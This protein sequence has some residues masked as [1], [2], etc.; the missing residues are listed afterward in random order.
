MDVRARPSLYG[1]FALVL[2]A[3][4][5]LLAVISPSDPDTF[6]HLKNGEHVLAVGLGSADVFSYTARGRPWVAHEWLFDVAAFALA[7]ALGY[8]ALVAAAAVLQGLTAWL[9]VRLARA[10]GAG[11]GLT[12]A[13]TGA[14]VVFI[15]PT[16]GVRP[17]IVTTLLAGAFSLVLLRY[18]RDPAHPRMLLALPPLMLAWVNLHASFPL[19]IALVAIFLAGGAAQRALYRAPTSTL[20][21]A[22]LATALVACAVATLINPAGV[23]LWTYPLPYLFSGTADI[24]II[25]EWRS[26]DFHDPVNL[27]FA[28]S[29][30]VLGVVGLGRPAIPSARRRFRARVRGRFDPT[31]VAVVAL[32]ATLALR[33]GRLVPVYGMLVLPVLGEAVARAWPAVSRK[34]EVCRRGRPGATAFDHALALVVTAGFAL[35]V[36]SSPQAQTGLTPRTDTRFAYPAGAAAYLEGASGARIFSEYAWGGYL[37]YRLHPTATVFI[38]GRADLF[39]QGVFADYMAVK[40]LDPT[41]RE[42]LDRTGTSFVLVRPDAALA[43]VLSTDLSWRRVFEDRVSVLYRRDD[44]T[45]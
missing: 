6:W 24:R 22:P 18:R 8:R 26:V 29:L 11:E 17:Q 9:F 21:L 14:F 39:R 27:V 30:V 40:G 1:V 35:Y 25:D 43:T 37:I 34:L 41:Y 33:Y 4:G 23:R 38:D 13:L 44:G 3:V 32:A 45:P 28:A 5:G 7:K 12:L 19:G 36:F 16:W 10:R 20:P 2:V 15:A 31:D 42:I